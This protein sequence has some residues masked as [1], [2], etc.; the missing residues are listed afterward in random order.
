MVSP[1][2]RVMSVSGAPVAK[3]SGTRLRACPFG[4]KTPSWCTAPVGLSATE[5]PP[6]VSA[7]PLSAVMTPATTPS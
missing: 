5:V 2:T 4:S 3:G 1:P 6:T 7:L